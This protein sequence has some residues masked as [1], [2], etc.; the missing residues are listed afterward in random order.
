MACLLLVNSSPTLGIAIVHYRSPEVA[1]DCLER[2]RRAAPLATVVLVDTA[3]EPEF[4]RE[5]ERHFPE[6]EFVPAAN[7][8]YSHAV[9][10]GLKRLHADYLVLMNADVLVARETFRALLE[11]MTSHPRCGAV[12][13][14]ALLPNGKPQ[15][16][17]V[18]YRRYYRRAQ[19]AKRAADDGVTASVPVRW[20]SGCLQLVRRETWLATGG[21]D[22]T[23]RF[24][25]EDLEFCLRLAE[26]GWQVR[27]AATPVV[28]LGGSSTPDHAAFH[29]EGRRGGL[30]VTRR[31]YPRP[32][33]W[34]QLTYLWSEAL[35]GSVLARDPRQREKHLQMLKLLRSGDLSRSPFGATLDERE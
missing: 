24:F 27:L 3:P 34:L 16:L 11:V 7:H 19:A 4:Q 22:E 13:P 15:P 26:R 33:A 32:V 29:I 28:H 14:L 12:G 30:A 20:V 5:L 25:N 35:V 6:V 21:Y 18:P 2:V 8:S 31:Y 23:L 1:L 17:G 10:V 9:N